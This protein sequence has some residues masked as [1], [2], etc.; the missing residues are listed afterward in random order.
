MI[1]MLTNVSSLGGSA[2]QADGLSKGL[3]RLSISPQLLQQ[4]SA[5][6]VRVEVAGERFGERL[7]DVQ[8]VCGRA[9]IAFGVTVRARRIV[10]VQAR[11]LSERKRPNAAL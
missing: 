9:V 7:H 5:D 8:P 3:A 1:Q 4:C 11:A 6:A 10:E 2:R